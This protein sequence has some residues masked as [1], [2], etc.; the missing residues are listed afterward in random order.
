MRVGW[1]RLG[2]TKTLRYKENGTMVFPKSLKAQDKNAQSLWSKIECEK[3]WED[4]VADDPV[5]K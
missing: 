4:P 3:T 2:V 1:S 5:G